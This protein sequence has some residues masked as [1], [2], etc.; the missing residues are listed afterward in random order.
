MSSKRMLTWATALGLAVAGPVLGS[1]LLVPTHSAAAADEDEIPLPYNDPMLAYLTDT[2]ADAEVRAL[3]ERGYV[4]SSLRTVSLGSRCDVEICFA[5]TLVMHTFKTRGV[6]IRT[7]SILAEVTTN[8]TEVTG[9]RL[10]ELV[11]QPGTEPV[12]GTSILQA[13]MQESTVARAIERL[14]ASYRE[15]FLE[16]FEIAGN[17]GVAGCSSEV[18][19]V[20]SFRPLFAP[21][22]TTSIVALVS[23]EPIRRMV[24]SVNLVTLAD[25]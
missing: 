21:A 4:E 9:V 14:R 13:Y 22:A 6:D 5:R 16:T 18:L 12:F 19:V 10:V 8:A 23:V 17:C 24:E 15:A 2:T 25:K 1:A 7:Q 3:E 20:H 11:R